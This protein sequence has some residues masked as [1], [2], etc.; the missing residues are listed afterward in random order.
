MCVKGGGDRVAA[1]LV[2]L[3]SIAAAAPAAVA[4]P[5]RCQVGAVAG[6]TYG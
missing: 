4:Y 5:V 3:A 2:N 1:S 6:A